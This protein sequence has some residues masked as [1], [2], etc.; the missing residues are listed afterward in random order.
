MDRRRFLKNSA[1]VLASNFF[2][3]SIFSKAFAMVEKKNNSSV[4][5][6][7]A[8]IIDDIGYS[9]PRA[10]DFLNVNIPMTFSVLPHLTHSYRIAVE[11]HGQGHEIM[12]HQPM[13]P[14]N[15]HLDPGPGALLVGYK[16]QKISQIMQENIFAAP[17]ATGVNNHMGSKFTSCDKQIGH[18][19]RVIKDSNLFFIDSLTSGHSVAHQTAKK[20]HMTTACRNI[21]LDNCLQDKYIRR[22]LY[23][24]EIH[25]KIHGYAIGIGHPFPQTAKAIRCFISSPKHS[26]VSFVHV[27]DILSFHNTKYS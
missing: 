1:F 27:S 20:L 5:P 2:G 17:Y 15:S 16:P 8:L 11:I 25:A 6:L 19:L 26:G 12:L 7:I 9:I 21:F 10:R 18:A 22:Q 13:E 4:Q 24:L 14:F 3:L 23:Q